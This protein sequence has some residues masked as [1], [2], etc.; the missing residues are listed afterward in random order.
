MMSET[1]FF[2]INIWIVIVQLTT[3]V[4]LYK[5]HDTIRAPNIKIHPKTIFPSCHGVY[6]LCIDHS[7]SPSFP[8]FQHKV[9]A[10]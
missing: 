9:V 2:G 7:P 5:H 3:R 4:N 8:S 10:V 1:Y 6:C